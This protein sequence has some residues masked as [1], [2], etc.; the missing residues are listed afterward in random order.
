MKKILSYTRYTRGWRPRQLLLIFSILLAI[1]TSAA[2]IDK[3]KWE[4]GRNTFKVNC[5]SCHSPVIAQTGPALMGVTKRW[6]DAGSYNGKTGKEWLYTWIRNWS[7]PVN[8]KYP[9]AVR[10]QNY[11]PTQMNIFPTLSDR[12]ID[13]L[14]LYVEN[15][16]AGGIA[17]SDNNSAGNTSWA[18]TV[19][20]ILITLVL[21][22]LVIL[23]LIT[24]NNK[25]RE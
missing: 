3:T 4:E 12:E 14:L 18:S 2:D 25:I 11:S 8:D 22:A 10:M 24:R 9:Y 1:S 5:A 19:Q 15:P 13:N 21:I 23:F 6:Q 16:Y 17:N 7:I 20:F